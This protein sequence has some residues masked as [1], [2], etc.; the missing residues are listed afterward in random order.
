MHKVLA[1]CGFG[2]RRA[3]EDM[4]IAGRITVNRLPAEVGQKVGP[5]D[6]VRINGELVKVR[7]TEPRPRILMYHK[8]AGEIV[9]RDDPEGRPTVFTRLPSI[10]TGK[11]INVGRLDFNTEGLLL[12]TNSGDL[13][14]R[15]M[16][17]RYEV[18]REYAVRIMGR[19]TEEQMQ[20]LVDGVQLEDGPAKC[21]KV[22]DGG[23]EEEGANH[24]YH[25]VLKEGRNREVRRLFEA[26]ALP[27]S[28]LIRTRY[29]TLAMPSLLKRGDLMELEAVDVAAVVESAG[30]NRNTGGGASRPRP[31]GGPPRGKPGQ[32][33]RGPRGPGG[34]APL[35]EDAVAAQGEAMPLADGLAAVESGAISPDT[36]IGEG[37]APIEGARPHDGPRQGGQRPPGKHG[38]RH[39]KG[40]PRPQGQGGGPRPQGQGNGPRQHG[41][42]GGPNPQGQGGGPR[43]QG[44]GGGPRTQGQGGGPRTQ[45]QGGGPRAQGQGGGPRTHG[46]APRPQGQGGG[47]PDFDSVQPQSNANAIGLRQPGEQRRKGNFGGSNKGGFGGGQNRSGFGGQ[48]KGGFGGQNNSGGP[49]P[50]RQH[51]DFDNQQPQSNANGFPFG[52]VGFSTPG[53]PRGPGGNFNPRG[54][55]NGPRGPGGG[56]GGQFRGKGPG[57]AGPR[58]NRGPGG[59]ANGNVA[60]GAKRAPRPDAD[61]N[62]ALPKPP[63]ADDDD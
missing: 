56:G 41:Q 53:A 38:G 8:P 22:E 12:F 7:F 25:V 26:L 34:Q 45:G 20:L 29:G 11:W 55:R 58:P 51:V 10:G 31:Q 21:E 44:Q 3:M 32:H 5:G 59:E 17:P 23:G 27:V 52:A 46:G 6:E 16:H 60:P 50:N 47:R 4:I 49:R 36:P 30:L 40:G 33:Q 28:R 2:S 9:T 37:A 43:P 42:G 63:K 18:E 13:A 14:N 48:N 39:G 61:G 15:L 35:R 62:V 19:M 1:S 54:N 24:W 57:N